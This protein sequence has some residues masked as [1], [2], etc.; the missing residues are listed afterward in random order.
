MNRLDKLRA[1]RPLGADWDERDAHIAQEFVFETMPDVVAF[2]DAFKAHRAAE[3]KFARAAS[4]KEPGRVADLARAITEA[5]AAL[6]AA[7][8]K[9]EAD[10]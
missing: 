10:T 5:R 7:L 3:Q 1:I 4:G 2:V 9:L 6:D 8:A